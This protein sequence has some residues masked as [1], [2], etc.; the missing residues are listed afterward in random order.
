M[1]SGLDRAGSNRAYTVLLATL[2]STLSDLDRTGFNRANTSPHA[3][4][5]VP[6]HDATMPSHVPSQCHTPPPLCH[7]LTPHFTCQHNA[8][9]PLPTC[10]PLP[11]PP[12]PTPPYDPAI[13]MP[14]PDTPLRTYRV[15]PQIL[16]VRLRLRERSPDRGV[17]GS[18]KARCRIKICRK[19]TRRRAILYTRGGPATFS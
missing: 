12:A 10:R 6:P 11:I 7:H 3:I 2:H 17:G 18:T 5:H 9:A 4:L 13:H 14:P 19:K 15:Y 8:M 16:S 1:L